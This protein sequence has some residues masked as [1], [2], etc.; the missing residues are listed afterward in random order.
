MK[1]IS[2]AEL[3]AR[4]IQELGLDSGMLDLSSNEAIAN[5][6]RRAAGLFCPCSTRTLVRAVAKPLEGLVMDSDRLTESVENMLD[7]LASYGD[8]LE[9]RDFNDE[10]ET[11]AEAGSL[12]F[13]APP[14]FVARQSGS[15]LLLGIAPEQNSPLPDEIAVHVEYSNHIRRIPG[16]AVADLHASLRQLG[17]IEL[18]HESWT[19]APPPES[20]NRLLDRFNALL[21]KAPP[22]GEIAGLSLLDPTKPVRYYRGRWVEPR[23]QTGRF[24]ARRPQAYGA[25]LWCYVEIT[26]GKPIKFLDLPVTPTRVRGCD[27][28]WRIQ[29]AIDALRGSPQRIGVRRGSRTDSILDFYSPVPMWAQRRWDSI[30]S[31]ALNSDSLF[32]YCFNAREVS[33]EIE[34]AREMLWVVE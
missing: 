5:A 20:P 31:P 19:K 3:H 21:D 34:F 2:I 11:S 22:S 10:E 15:A 24:V 17:L 16:N 25:G 4:K 26:D 1:Q 7:R 27:E 28:A 29:M 6:L 9:N 30:G 33:E 12:L 14:S 18:S 13:A 8:L 32:S 23:S